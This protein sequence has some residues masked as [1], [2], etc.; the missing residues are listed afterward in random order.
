MGGRFLGLEVGR[1][2][3]H[4]CFIFGLMEGG[5]AVPGVILWAVL[6]MFF[7]EFHRAVLQDLVQPVLETVD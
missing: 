7:H 6:L 3:F 1:V 5:F 2:V 4:L